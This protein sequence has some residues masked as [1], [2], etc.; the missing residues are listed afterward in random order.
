MCDVLLGPPWEILRA[1]LPP[2]VLLRLRTTARYWNKGDNYGPYG[3]FFLFLFKSG[4]EDASTV[5]VKGTAPVS[6]GDLQATYVWGR[7]TCMK[8]MLSGEAWINIR[9]GLFPDNVVK[10]RATARCWNGDLGD[11]FFILL[12]MKQYTSCNGDRV[13]Q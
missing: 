1:F 6:T 9:Q 3:D 4:G 12:K 8:V 13:P 10:M 7:I 11:L 5:P 2:D